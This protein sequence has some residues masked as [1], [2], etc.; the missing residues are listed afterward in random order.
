MKGRRKGDDEEEFA[1]IG[2]QETGTDDELAKCSRIHSLQAL[3]PHL[4]PYGSKKRKKKETSPPPV[5]PDGSLAS[6]GE[7][8]KLKSYFLFFALLRYS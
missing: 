2:V 8:G 5:V 3:L 6:A 4:A 1:P 7:L